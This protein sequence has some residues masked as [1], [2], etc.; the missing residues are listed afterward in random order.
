VRQRYV[1]IMEMHRRLVAL[2]VFDFICAA[3]LLVLNTTGFYESPGTEQRL[4]DASV[5]ISA[6]EP[7]P[8]ADAPDVGTTTRPM[9]SELM[10]AASTASGIAQMERSEAL[11]AKRVSVA[12]L[13]VLLVNLFVLYPVMRRRAAPTVAETAGGQS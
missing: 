1:H 8:I 13:V 7:R 10:T 4:A 5:R 11:K 2:F 9:P 12:S 6:A 3:I